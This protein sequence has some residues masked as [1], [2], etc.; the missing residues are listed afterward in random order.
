MA[1]YP[2]GWIADRLGLVRSALLL[3][4]VSLVSS[5]LLLS[6][7]VPGSLML[8][9]LL[10]AGAIR[11]LLTLATYAAAID[12]CGRADHNMRVVAARFSIGAILG[13]VGA[14]AAMTLAGMNMLPIW[15]VTLC[16]ALM[17]YLCATLMAIVP[18]RGEP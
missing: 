9:V 10:F 1:Q 4:S 18:S 17:L 7:R 12:D 3:S 16:G 6:A 15:F 13:P 2:V 5:T 14:G 11:A 8:A